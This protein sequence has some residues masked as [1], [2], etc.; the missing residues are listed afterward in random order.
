M[1]EVCGR[2]TQSAGWAS[3][4]RVRGRITRAGPCQS[5]T[6]VEKSKES[7]ETGAQGEGGVAMGMLCGEATSSVLYADGVPFPCEGQRWHTS[8]TMKLANVCY[9]ISLHA[10]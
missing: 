8:A 2:K 7:S 9:V 4:H 5:L 6:A 1:L 3:W 10:Q